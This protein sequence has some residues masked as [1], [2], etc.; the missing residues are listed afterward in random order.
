[1]EY[2]NCRD[3]GYKSKA[4]KSFLFKKIKVHFAHDIKCDGHHK[5]RLVSTSQL[6]NAPLSSSHS[7]VMSLKGIRLVL[8]I[9]KPNVLE[10]WG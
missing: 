3:L 10:S 6:I 1:M 9:V 2:E 4:K 5:T 7:R 8:F